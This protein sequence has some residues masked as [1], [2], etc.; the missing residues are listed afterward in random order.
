MHWNHDDNAGNL[1]QQAPVPSIELVIADNGSGFD[2]AITTWS[3]GL[4][5]I[6]ERT[7]AM[8]G[9]WEINTSPGK[10]VK[11]SVQVPLNM[12]VANHA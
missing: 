4:S 12:Q 6:R 10:G 2:P 7:E 1:Q 8:H 9:I 11:L 3:L 5:G